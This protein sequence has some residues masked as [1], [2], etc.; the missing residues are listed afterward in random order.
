MLYLV[1]PL[2][3]IALIAALFGFGGI[4][5]TVVGFAKF[6]FVMAVAAL[7]ASVIFEGMRGSFG[8]RL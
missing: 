7:A 5:G 1:I 4:G 2:L 6:V 3:I 8:R